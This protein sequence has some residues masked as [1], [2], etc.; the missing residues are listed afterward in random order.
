MYKVKVDKETCVGCGACTMCENFE[1]DN[2][3]KARPI[4]SEVEELGCNKEAED[5]C[6]VQ[7]ITVE[8]E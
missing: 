1:M 5:L 7:A 6:P 2:D 4:K 3:G 8:E